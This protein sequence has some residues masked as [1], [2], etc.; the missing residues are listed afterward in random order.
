[1][2]NYIEKG[3]DQPSI[4][5]LYVFPIE[6]FSTSNYL[7]LLSLKK[8]IYYYSTLADSSFQYFFITIFVFIYVF[9]NNG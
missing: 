9:Q 2:A 6:I 5:H 4:V 3:I 8:I 1:M 7:L